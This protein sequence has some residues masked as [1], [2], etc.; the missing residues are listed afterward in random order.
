MNLNTDRHS[1]RPT[2]D[3]KSDARANLLASIHPS[4]PRSN[5]FILPLSLLSC[6]SFFLRSATLLQNAEWRVRSR[7][8]RKE[9]EERGSRAVMSPLRRD[10]PT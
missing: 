7:E 10:L 4:S 8:G 3:K 9:R 5:Q 2:L 1:H 6:P